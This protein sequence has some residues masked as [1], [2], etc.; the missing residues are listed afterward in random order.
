M[1]GYLSDLAEE[2]VVL[3]TLKDISLTTKLLPWRAGVLCIGPQVLLRLGKVD[4]LDHTRQAI[5][6]A[7]TPKEGAKATFRKSLVGLQIVLLKEGSL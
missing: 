4:F 6:L 3:E 2:F 1:S 7:F 5:F